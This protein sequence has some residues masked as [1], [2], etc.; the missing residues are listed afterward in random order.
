MVPPE[1]P[2]LFIPAR[3]GPA[4]A[5]L[6]YEP[7]LVA[8]A[9]VRFTDPK[10]GL[11]T[12]SDLAYLVQFSG[13]VVPIDWDKA[14]ATS[15]PLTDLEKTPAASAQFASLPPAAAQAKSYAGWRSEFSS[16]LFRNA[17]L[18]MRQASREQRDVLVARIRAQY[19][20]K[21][22]RLEER[23]RN[24]QQV[25]EREQGQA[26]AAG[27]Q[28]AISLGATVLGSLLGR[29]RISA[30]S[31]GRATTAARGVGRTIDQ[32]QD[33][34]RAKADVGAAQ[35]ELTSLN[36]ELEGKLSGL[37]AIAIRPT[38]SNIAVEIL[39]LAWV[40]FWQDQQGTQT[41]GWG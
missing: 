27:L 1:I 6:V 40:P 12:T 11:D 33:V 34:G 4:G 28:T 19:A 31:L 22:Q 25:V 23:I 18:D 29:K 32:Q 41:P 39:A 13:G 24:A 20:P 17:T 10:S 3:S 21:V 37:D 26:R 15:I 5:T 7:R 35:A 2:Q 14:E 36:Q 38:K 16:W 9:K 30:T 8:A